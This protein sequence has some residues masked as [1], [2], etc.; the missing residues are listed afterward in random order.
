MVYKE[1]NYGNFRILWLFDGRNRHLWS[2][3]MVEREINQLKLQ[4][5]IKIFS[6]RNPQTNL[7]SEDAQRQLAA[8]LF[9]FIGNKNADNQETCTK[10]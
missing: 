3:G 9:S 1:I 4:E 6:Q 7:L 2:L 5:A 10:T 8:W